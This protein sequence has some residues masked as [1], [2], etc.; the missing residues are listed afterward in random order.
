MKARTESDNVIIHIV[1]D[2][3]NRNVCWTFTAV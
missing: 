3:Y 2:D 1:S